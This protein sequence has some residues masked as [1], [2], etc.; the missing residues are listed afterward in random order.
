MKRNLLLSLAIILGGIPSLRAQTASGGVFNVDSLRAAVRYLASD[1]LTGRRTGT[2]G[3]EDA[4]RYLAGKF[5][6]AGLATVP[7]G[8]GYLH[9]FSYLAGVTIGPRNA[10]EVKGPDGKMIAARQGSDFSPAGFSSSGSADAPVAFAGYGITAKELSYDDYAGIDAK[11]KIVLIMRRSPDADNPHGDF[12]RFE[13]LTAKVSNAREHGAA[14]IIFINQPDDSSALPS[15]HFDRNFTHAD[16]PAIIARASL[17]DGLRNSGGES[18]AALQTRID[19]DRKPASFVSSGFTARLRT[20]LSLQRQDVPNVIGMLRGH[21]PALNDQ[22]IVIGGHFDHL[23][24]GGEG[25]LYGGKEPSIHHGADDNAS[26]AAGVVALADRF[27]RMGNN[28][29]TLI[30]VAFNG[31]EEG[32]LGSAALM[33]KPPFDASKVIAMVNMDMIGRLDTSLIVQGT[34]TSPLWKDLLGT[35][36]A[37][38]FPLKMVED[39]FGPSDHSSFYSKGIPVL[40]FFTGLHSDYHRPSDTWEKINYP[41]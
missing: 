1:G 12:A 14:A 25:S 7:G 3:N 4:A 31:E 34:G 28:G 39:G 19:R 20:D 26:G 13:G 17:F 9:R 30:F 8:T 38:R 35:T 36:N 41:G 22:I 32:L 18:L 21:D 6:A 10:L 24:W 15:A 29:R 16:I 5:S 2:A 37:G 11:G 27:A 33:E 40:F 23:G